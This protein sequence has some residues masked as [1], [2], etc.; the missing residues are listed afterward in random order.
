MY[1]DGRCG[2]SL[3]RDSRR[4]KLFYYVQCPD[5]TVRSGREDSVTGTGAV[6]CVVRL[7]MFL[8]SVGCGFVAAVIVFVLFYF[9]SA[10]TYTDTY[11]SKQSVIMCL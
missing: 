4:N 11:S 2:H 6:F 10:V 1:R 7:W 9:P 8:S 5:P 3:A